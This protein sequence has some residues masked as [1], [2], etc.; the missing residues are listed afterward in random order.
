MAFQLDTDGDDDANSLYSVEDGRKSTVTPDMNMMSDQLRLIS[1]I[2]S[3][4]DPR[5]L[6]ALQ[7]DRQLNQS[8]LSLELLVKFDDISLQQ[9]VNSWNLDTLNHKSSIIR[10]LFINGVRNLKSQT[11]KQRSSNNNN[12]NKKRDSVNIVTENEMKMM[13]DLLKY[14]YFIIDKINK[15][16]N[17]TKECEMK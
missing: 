12:K 8:N 7:I 4:H 9:T 6:I 13:E 1:Q 5:H 11:R 3:T 10:D 16:E 15:F 14:E 17:E 2:L